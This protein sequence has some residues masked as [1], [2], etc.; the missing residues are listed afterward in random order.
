[1]ITGNLALFLNIV[2]IMGM[3]L[4]ISITLISLGQT[5]ILNRLRAF[6]AATRRRLLWIMLLLPW[7]AG[8]L[9]TALV[10][11]P[12]Q[13]VFHAHGLSLLISLFDW[14]HP[15]A[16]S[17]WSWH[18]VFAA[19]VLLA[20]S[21]LILRALHR[22]LDNTRHTRAV[23]DFAEATQ[24][25]YYSIDADTFSAFTCGLL[26]P[27][28]IIST[29]LLAQLTPKEI[30][31]VLAHENEHRRRYDPL[32]KWLFNSLCSPF[33]SAIARAFRHDMLIAM[34]QCADARAAACVQDKTAVAL[35]LLKVQR[36][37][38]ATTAP[39]NLIACHAA[40]N[41]LEE[42]IRYLLSVPG[43][44]AFPGFSLLGVATLLGV[45][46]ALSADALH[47]AIDFLLSH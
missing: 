2:I 5:A 40:V 18:S 13:A 12:L 39:S 8:L 15:Y 44:Q 32:Q 29:A 21:A 42:R 23:L 37:S 20:V 19:T 10:M 24:N 7:I 41:D 31:V 45:T 6:C 25:R 33:P 9:A 35:T 43:T 22:L 30:E 34:E 1:M 28:C 16:F 4:I 38:V 27:R 46:C 47:H 14:H 3:S 11:P 36:A 26:K 17:P